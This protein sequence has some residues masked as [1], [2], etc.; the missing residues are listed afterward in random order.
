MYF[1]KPFFARE[2]Q[3]ALSISHSGD[4]EEVTGD[5]GDVKEVPWVDKGLPGDDEDVPGDAES[6]FSA[7]SRI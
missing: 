7:V 5:A 3:T 6:I 4:D 1:G 2:T